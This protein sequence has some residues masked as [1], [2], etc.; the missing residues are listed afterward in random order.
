MRARAVATEV[1]VMAPLLVVLTA[2]LFGPAF[3]WTLGGRPFVISWIDLAAGGIAIAGAVVAV[4]RGRVRFDRV[5]LGYLALLIV[6][7]VQAIVLPGALATLGASSRFVTAAMLVFGLSQLVSDEIA[8]DA[9]RAASAWE[10]SPLGA[11]GPRARRDRRLTADEPWR[12]PLAMTLFGGVLAVWVTT[13][14][15]AALGDVGLANFYDVKNAVVT[16]LGASNY[17]AGFLLMT[18]LIVAVVAAYD[19]RY[20]AGA[21]VC[22]VGMLATLSRGA[23]IAL[24]LASLA[25]ALAMRSRRI[26]VA[27]VSVVTAAVLALVVIF[28]VTAPSGGSEPAVAVEGAGSGG[29][30]ALLEPGSITHQRIGELLVT[31]TGG[32]LELYRVSWR[33]FLDNPVLGVGVN[34][35]ESVT[36][37]TAEPHVNAHNLELH[38]LA[39]TGLLGTLAY[40]S[41]WALLAWRLWFAP[42]GLRRSALAVAA[43]GLFIHAQVEALAFTRAIEAVLALL[44]VIAG[45]VP[46]AR[47]IR[48]VP[49]RQRSA[50]APIATPVTGGAPASR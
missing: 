24:V 1:T 8:Q 25:G 30:V 48:V 2:L 6:I 14:L 31:A 42:T 37:G 44:L 16:P 41:L 29:S 33:A 3:I 17:L 9:Q 19:R 35:L 18:G 38:A 22:V 36:A 28:A 5:L 49:L 4:R 20:L 40:L 12:W 39:T 43:L 34:H 50:S 11:Q 23:A 21:L 45:T 7:V 10:P 32:R 26:A 13:M 27:A 15:V 47:G 46:A